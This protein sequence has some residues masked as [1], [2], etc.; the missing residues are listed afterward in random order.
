MQITGQEQNQ[1][2]WRFELQLA[3]ATGRA[4]KK[5]ELKT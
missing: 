4:A 1:K 5:G 2:A 3:V